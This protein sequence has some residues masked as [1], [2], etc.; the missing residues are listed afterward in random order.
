MCDLSI[1]R[2]ERKREKKSRQTTRNDE[3]II[4]FPLGIKWYNEVFDL[5]I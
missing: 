2:G 3:W 1:L 4:E 5:W